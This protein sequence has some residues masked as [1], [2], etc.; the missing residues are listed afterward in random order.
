[1]TFRLGCT[2]AA[3]LFKRIAEP[4][5]VSQR[6]TEYRV[7]ADR[8]HD[9][10]TEIYSIDRVV[11][12]R[13]NQ[14]EAIDYQPF[15]SLQHPYQSREEGTTFWITSRRAPVDDE[16][17]NDLYLSLVDLNFRPNAVPNDVLTVHVT[18][19]NR[20]FQ[21]APFVNS[22]DGFSLEAS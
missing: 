9:A 1:E 21:N 20:D 3:N 4:I 19:T 17:R 2:P 5:Q 15:Y 10:M 16:E 12:S 18:C 13:P 6:K 8:Y 22:D 14:P 11:A 7:V